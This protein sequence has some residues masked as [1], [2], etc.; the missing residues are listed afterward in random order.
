MNTHTI[1][2]YFGGKRQNKSKQTRPI[3]DWPQKAHKTK[4]DYQ[5]IMEV[6]HVEKTFLAKRQ[7]QIVMNKARAT[8]QKGR[9]MHSRSENNQLMGA[10]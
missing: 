5:D 3:F 10:I 6:T 4:Q 8:F 2:S 1:F 7:K 9:H